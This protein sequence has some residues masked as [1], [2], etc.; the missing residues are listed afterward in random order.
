MNPKTKK[1]V[2]NFIF[3]ALIALLLWPTSRT[4]FQQQLMNIGLFRPKL[5]GPPKTDRGGTGTAD[6]ADHVTFIRHSGETVRVTEL[7]GKVVFINFWATW[8]GPCRAEMPS[9][10]VLYDKFK[11]NPQVEFLVVEI[12]GE[13][14][15]ASAFMKKQKLTLP[16]SYPNSEIPQEWLSGSIPSTVILDKSGNLVTRHEGMADYS[17]PEVTAFIQDL[18]DK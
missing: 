16:V 15:K 10:N 6:P 17:A 11:D 3:V 7:R 1:L 4:Y 12:E 2:G 8:C 13:K 14:E 9:I 18:I 5:E